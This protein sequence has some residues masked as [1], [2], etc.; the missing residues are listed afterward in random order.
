MRS[1]SLLLFMALPAIAADW[2]PAP[3]PLMTKWGKQITADKTPWA[4][5]PR[6]QLVRKEWANLN[7]LW[8]YAIRPKGEKQPAK[9]DGKILV[10][11]CAE[12]ALSGVGKHPT[13]K[14]ELWYRRDV[15]A[16]AWKGRRVLLHFEAVDW[17]ATVWVNGKELGTHKGM[18]DPFTFDVTDSL[19]DG[20]GE[21]VVRVWDPTDKGSQPLGKQIHNPHG[22]WYTPV[23]GIWQTVWMEPV[24]DSRI[25]HV[26]PI[27]EFRGDG[28]LVVKF[29]V[30]GENLQANDRVEVTCQ[31]A[32]GPGENTHKSG[33]L[34]GGEPVSVSVNRGDYEPW[35]P[36]NPKLYPVT[37]SLTRGGSTLDTL[38]TYF[39]AR[40]VGVGKDADGV[41][42]LLL[43]GKPLF[44][45]GPL[46][47]GWWPDGLLTPPSDEAMKYDL[48]VLKKLGFNMLRKHIKVEPSRYYYH[49]DKLG[50]LVWQDMPS[51]INRTK[52]HFVAPGQKTDAD[53]QFTDAEKKQFRVELKAMIDHLRGFGCIY[54]WVPFNEGWGQH[55]VNAT[56]KW[57]KEYDPTRPVNGPSG[58]E[59]R[60]YGDMKDAHIYP[61]PGMFPVMKD[62]VSVLG[63][64]GGLGLPVKG[65]LWKDT[66]N[67]GYRTY[68]TTD[69]LRTNYH[70]LMKRMHP[71]IGKGLAAAIYTQ[72]TDVEIE[73]NGLMTYDREVL[74]FDIAETKKWHDML[75]SP[76]PAV[77]ELVP[78]SEMIAQVWQYTTDKPAEGWTK[79][80]F[81]AKGW[82]EGKGGFGTKMTPGSRIGT[83]WAGKEIWLR[84]TF[85]LKELPTGEIFLRFHCD[86]DGEAF[87]NGVSA[88]KFPGYTT[89][90]VDVPISEAA[91][92]SLKVG[93]NSLAVYAKNAGGGQYIDAGLV[94]L[95]PAK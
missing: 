37:V 44:Q 26:E 56:L 52:K 38:S 28:G 6:P 81:D 94:R 1:L 35:T 78:T 95:V 30:R 29:K 3:T 65:H 48:E 90:Y 13:E 31:L 43:N 12:S 41:Q 62:R 24:G 55:D 76:P 15:D 59:D 91:R 68:K 67:W 74:K 11:F 73:V 21:L 79:S 32:K 82:K 10:P 57:V 93:T 77:T 5:Y 89:E 8:D 9:W 20:K 7:G 19:K 53:D 40:T 33:S 22:I 84:R 72:T 27:A 88:A 46:D 80:A 23:T 34:V 71:L 50:L 2:K 85:E 58:W 83:E 16:S 4:E 42:R 60:G 39:A 51:A 69:E 92:K 75:F 64:F 17:E 18:H 70:A 47:Q 49:C 86:E 63:E 66:G 14:D 45:Y 25:S 36:D 61:G 54:C 87:L